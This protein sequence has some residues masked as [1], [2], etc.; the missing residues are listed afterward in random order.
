[1]ILLLLICFH[2]RHRRSNVWIQV[3]V[4]QHREG[5]FQHH[6]DVL[7]YYNQLLSTSVWL[8]C[9]STKHVDK[10]RKHNEKEDDCPKYH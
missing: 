2:A 3:R 5:K 9:S 10:L 4:S 6:P 7:I 8:L 1:M